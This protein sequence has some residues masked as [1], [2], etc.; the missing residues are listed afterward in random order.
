MAKI[1]ITGNIASGKSVVE[2]FL[3][4][5][6]FEVFDTDKIAHQFLLSLE[7][8]KNAFAEF[9]VFEDGQISRKKLGALVFRNKE[10]LLC[11]ESIIHPKIKD[12]IINLPDGVFV[13]VPQLF[14]AK[15]ED[16][17]DKIIFVSADK[18]I[19]LKR[20]M[21][22]NSM[23]EEEALLRINAQA[24]EKSKIDKSSFVINNNG[25]IE[26]LEKQINLI[27]SELF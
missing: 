4:A 6:G 13:S 5:R 10:L 9:D 19:R 24:D 25:Q 15:M 7:E 21:K 11:L 1:A 16:L 17:F 27:L 20:L 22:R 14:E 2:S 8:V 26:S 23:S 12:F 18:E 3:K